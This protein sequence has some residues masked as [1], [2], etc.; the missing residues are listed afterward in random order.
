MV[1]VPSKDPIWKVLVFWNI[2]DAILP[3]LVELSRTSQIFEKL[4]ENFRDYILSGYHLVV[5]SEMIFLVWGM[6]YVN[7]E[8]YATFS[9]L[10][11]KVRQ[12]LGLS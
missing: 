5:E 9:G 6:V 11:L 7:H 12:A 10:I 1:I 3:S 8:L 2:I 4:F